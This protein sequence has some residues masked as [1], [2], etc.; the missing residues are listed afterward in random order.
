MRYRYTSFFW[1]KSLVACPR[2]PL[3]SASAHRFPSAATHHVL[4]DIRKQRRHVLPQRHRR[5][6]VPDGILPAA[7]VSTAKLPTPASTLPLVC[8]LRVQSVAKLK[9]LALPRRGGEHGANA[10]G[11]HGLGGVPLRR[12]CGGEGVVLRP[13]SDSRVAPVGAIAMLAD[14]GADAEGL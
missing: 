12:L 5:N 9:C 4:D 10:V 8:E 2:R 6:G 1:S 13:C 3:A 11:G 7:P 14:G